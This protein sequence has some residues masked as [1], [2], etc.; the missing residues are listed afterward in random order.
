MMKAKKTTI[1]EVELISLG[2]QPSKVDI[3]ETY[4]PAKKKGGVRVKDVDELI[5]K[6][7]KEAKVIWVNDWLCKEM[8]YFFMF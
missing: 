4:E 8:T 1:E 7:Q 3:F 2:L 6:L 5:E